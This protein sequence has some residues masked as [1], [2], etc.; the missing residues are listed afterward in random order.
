M[1]FIAWAVGFFGES[2]RWTHRLHVKTNRPLI[3]VPRRV[4][5]HYQD[6]S[7]FYNLVSFICGGFCLIVCKLQLMWVSE[8]RGMS[9]CC[10]FYR[11]SDSVAHLKKKKQYQKSPLCIYVCCFCKR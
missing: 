2:L 6:L 3:L 8:G 11:P 10:L 9:Q 1:A 7:V 5:F 4:I